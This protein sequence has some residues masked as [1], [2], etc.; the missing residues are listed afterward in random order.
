M[1]IFDRVVDRV[2]DAIEDVAARARVPASIDFRNETNSSIIVVMDSDRESHTI[3]PH[4][5]AT[6]G[7]ANVA[8]A[9]TFYVKNESGVVIYSRR[10]GPIGAKG[11]Y[12]WNGSTF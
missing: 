7:Q 4:G 10:V 6:F 5:Q 12:G 1:S 9:P 2:A 8:D 3:A 11:S